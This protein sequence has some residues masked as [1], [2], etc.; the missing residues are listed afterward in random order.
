LTDGSE[1]IRN[2]KEE[3]YGIKVAYNAASGMNRKIS[4]ITSRRR[5]K[6][7]SNINSH[8]PKIKKI[9]RRPGNL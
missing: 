3:S 8:K 6:K 4:L 9:K 2:V 5:I 7:L 1:G